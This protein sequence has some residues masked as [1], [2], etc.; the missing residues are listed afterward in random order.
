V[1]PHYVVFSSSPDARVDVVAWDAHALRFFRTRLG[2]LGDV[3]APELRV[4]VT[5][6]RGDAGERALSSRERSAEDLALAEVAEQRAGGGGLVLVARRCPRVWLVERHGEEDPLALRLAMALASLHL[7]PVLDARG[8]DLFG[9]KT[10][11][12][13]LGRLE[14]DGE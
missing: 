13:K 12:E 6:P 8:P 9:V 7:G 2:L 11:R 4:H 3:E 1:G 14:G 5:P 10:A